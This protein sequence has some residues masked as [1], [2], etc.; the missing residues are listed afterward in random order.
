MLGF[1]LFGLIATVSGAHC[2]SDV[3]CAVME[4]EEEL[5]NLLQLRRSNKLY[6]IYKARGLEDVQDTLYEHNIYRCMH[7]VPLLEWDDLIAQRAQEWADT[8]PGFEHSTSDFRMQGDESCGENLAI[9]RPTMTGV[10]S[11]QLWYDEITLTDG[12]S[13]LVDSFSDATGH[14]TQVVWKSTTRIGCGGGYINHTSDGET[15]EWFLVVCQYCA[16]GNTEGLFSENVLAP[17]RS[18]AECGARAT[19][20]PATNTDGCV[21]PAANQGTC[22]HL[23]D[24][25]CLEC[26]DL[27]Q[28]C[29][30]DFVTAKCVCSCL[31]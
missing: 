8:T 30:Y 3:E 31:S 28:F 2:E 29:S 25:V 13:G 21:E 24:G 9:G 27:T 10:Q 26:A 16:A 17:V 4:K 23:G 5:S 19:T 7:D 11:T 14:Y 15:K 1:M 20:T 22:I 6:A 18:A 12:V